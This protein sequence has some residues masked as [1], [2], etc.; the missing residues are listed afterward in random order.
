MIP[1]P[2]LTLKVGGHVRVTEEFIPLMKSNH[3]HMGKTG[4]VIEF[5]GVR[6][7]GPTNWPSRAFVRLDD[8]TGIAIIALQYLEPIP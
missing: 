8:G 1:E 7:R 2:T 3:P 5:M 6:L 4:I